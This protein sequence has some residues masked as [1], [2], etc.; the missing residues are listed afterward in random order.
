MPLSF[1]PFL[2]AALLAAPAAPPSDF[3][4]D[5]DGD[6]R[7][8]V[9]DLHALRGALDGVVA[10]PRDAALRADVDGDGELTE[11]DYVSLTFPALDAV[12]IPPFGVVPAGTPIIHAVT[13]EFASQGATVVIEGAGFGDGVTANTV[14]V[15]DVPV[16]V[17]SATPRRIEFT[18]PEGVGVLSVTNLESGRR[19]LAASF[20]VTETEHPSF[21]PALPEGSVLLVT[22]DEVLL[23]NAVFT[24]PVAL[25]VGEQ[26]PSVFHVKLFFDNEHVEAVC[27]EPLQDEWFVPLPPCIDNAAGVLG[28]GA[29]RNNFLFTTTSGQAG[30]PLALFEVGFKVKAY[31]PYAPALTARVEAVAGEGF[32]AV[33]LGA[34]TPRYVVDSAQLHADPTPPPGVKEWLGSVADLPVLSGIAPTN[35]K[36]GTMISVAGEKIDAGPGPAVAWLVVIGKKVAVPYDVTD[37]GFLVK[38]NSAMKSGPLTLVDP[39]NG[40]VSNDLAFV[41]LESKPPRVE[42]SDP[43]SGLTQ[44]APGVAVRLG[45]SE[46]LD[47]AA[48]TYGRLIRLFVTPPGGNILPWTAAMSTTTAREST[49]R[50]RPL[51]PFPAGSIVRVEVDA[52]VTDLSGNPVVTPLVSEFV[53]AQ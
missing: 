41:A 15:G 27:V 50:L 38:A 32:P 21:D 46:A 26:L 9:A 37:A 33:P 40:R 18:V 1:T 53:V 29:V 22:P 20:V 8:D 43:A 19:G 31:R 49:V 44:V 17:T 3:L 13:P 6:F 23:P 36:S 24:V 16:Q 5:V 51:L 39:I 25:V 2:V 28:A 45:F 14:Q 52:S 35:A 10:L 47:G 7:I 4:G 42:W 11:L 34:P 12:S 30:G 48:L